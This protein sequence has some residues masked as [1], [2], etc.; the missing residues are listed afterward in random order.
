MKTSAQGAK[1]EAN[2]GSSAMKGLI[3]A[4]AKAPYNIYTTTL[5]KLEMKY[6]PPPAVTSYTDYG[7][8]KN[9]KYTNP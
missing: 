3:D 8:V 5:S 7:T 2:A 6:V 9:N 1:E 4:I